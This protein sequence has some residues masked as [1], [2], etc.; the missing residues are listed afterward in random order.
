MLER[1]SIA[2][3]ITSYDQKMIFDILSSYDG[4][5]AIVWDR[6]LMKQMNVIIS[7]KVLAERA[8][9]SNLAL[10]EPV[11]VKV[12]HVIYLL[13]P[14]L[15]SITMLTQNFLKPLTKNDKRLHHVMFVPEVS[16]NLREK[17]KPFKGV[18]S[19]T[20]LPIRWFPTENPL[21]ITLNQ[22]NLLYKILIDEDWLELYKCANSI[23][24]LE[25]QMGQVPTIRCKGEWSA[26]IVEM[27]KKIRMS[28]EKVELGEKLD[29]DEIILI[30]RW[31]DPITPVLTQLTFGGCIDEF[32]S[33]DVQ[34][35]IRVPS[36]EYDAS[37]PSTNEQ[38]IDI[39]LNNDELYDQLQDQ[40]IYAIGS[41]IREVLNEL[42][43][44]EKQ[45][46][47]LSVAEMKVHIKS[48]PKLIKK[49]HSVDTF[50]R[51]AEMIQAGLVDDF[52]FGIIQC[53]KEILSGCP[54]DKMIPFIENAIIEA[55]H[56]F[57]I[58]RLICLHS[59]V[60]NGLKSAVLQSYR[61]LFI[62]SYGVEMLA[63][64]TR[65]QIAGLIKEES[66]TD[67]L[68]RKYNNPMNFSSANRQMKLVI[69]EFS[70]NNPK[71]TSY[72]YSGYASLLIRYIEAGFH[73]GWRDWTTINGSIPVARSSMNRLLFVVGGITRA[74]MSCVRTFLPMIQFCS[75]TNVL[76]G[77][78]LIQ[79]FQSL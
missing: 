14:T 48:I 11:D 38:H 68:S 52:N 20:S 18:E 58:L 27:L 54:S 69:N 42:R 3:I 67:K 16:H 2:S 12:D 37:G 9:S 24:Q 5:K 25:R 49:K 45:L 59:L 26:K 47:T 43:E 34:G 33:I 79:A 32:Y 44:E 41:K 17:L 35:K 15:D 13:A 29:V 30:D 36:K 51:V 39:H 53:E 28:N 77:D 6:K 21:F 74:E 50:T 1:K 8:V 40:H 22:P 71:D 62:Q 10:D 23:Y 64:W 61:K 31:L 19:I 65:L 63:L 4:S 73:N 46:Q 78:K 75:T 72:A 7:P 56:S 76:S 70:E 66:Q 57:R 60:C 55:K